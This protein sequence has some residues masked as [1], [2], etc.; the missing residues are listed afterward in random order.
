MKHIT[1]A[2]TT[3]LLA[4]ALLFG[5]ASMSSA[6]P[7]H[8]AAH[9]SHHKTINTPG[10]KLYLKD[11]HGTK[12]FL[13]TVSSKPRAAHVKNPTNF[14]RI[15]QTKGM[16]TFFKYAAKKYN[17][18]QAFERNVFACY[19]D[20]GLSVKQG[21]ANT[22][23]GSKLYKRQAKLSNCVDHMIVKYHMYD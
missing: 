10:V 15:S 16:E 18:S 14:Q 21:Y 23:R 8:H 6:A 12:A 5:G 11:M 1:Q 20:S 22:K 9:K 13:K 17:T 19:V 2:L 4:L 3:S 7:A